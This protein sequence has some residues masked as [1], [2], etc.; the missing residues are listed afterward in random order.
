MGYCIIIILIFNFSACPLD[1]KYCVCFDGNLYIENISAYFSDIAD[2]PLL[3][4]FAIM[5]MITCAIH[6][7]LSV[8]VINSFNA[9]GR[10]VI[11]ALTMPPIWMIGIILTLAID[12]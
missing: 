8:T 2:Q 11:H 6:N 7:A 10:T 9:L 4:L 5:I 1:Q 3:I 12:T